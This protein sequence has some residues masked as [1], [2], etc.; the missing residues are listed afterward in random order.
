MKKLALL[1]AVL[2]G[3]AAAS[4]AGVSVHIGIP[5]PPI[6]RVI[7]G[8]PA[9]VVVAP[10]HCLPPVV[11]APPCGPV[12]GYPHG[13]YTHNHGHRYYRHGHYTSHGHSYGHRS[14]GRD[15]RHHGR[16]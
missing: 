4:Q 16:H 12:Y 2:L 3:T 14:H 9:P 7:F 8:H 10:G 11:V 13:H 6:P 1:A 5:L 15:H